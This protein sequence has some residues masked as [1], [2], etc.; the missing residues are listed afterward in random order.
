MK[1]RLSEK[2]CY[3]CGDIYGGGA[4]MVFSLLFMNFLVLVEGLPVVSAT[5]IIF[6]GKVWDAITDPIVG[7]ISD[8]TRTRFGRRRI[9]FLIGIVPVFL[10]F[11][12]LFYS[13]G[14]ESVTAKVIYYAFSYMFFGTAF[15]IVMIP[16]NAILSDI[17]SDYD[18]RTSFTTMRMVFSG[19]A[20]LIA[21]VVPG[22]IIKSVGGNQNGPEQKMG[23]LIMAI[24][25]GV[26]FG[27]SWL[28]TF[29]GTRE[30][31]NLPPAEKITVKSY[32]SVFKNPAYRNFLGIFLSFQVA[33]DLVLALFIFYIDIVVLKYKSYE[34]IVG[35]LLVCSVILMVVMGAL[36]RKKGKVFPLFIGIPVWLL[37]TVAFIWIDAG[38]PVYVL[39][40][41]AALIAVGSAA[42]NLATWSLLT[43]IYDID[44][45]RTGKRREGVYSGLTTF[46]RKFASGVAV[47]LLGYGLRAMGFD[48]NEYSVLK[49][50]TA[51]FDPA[52]YAQS[53]VVM[54]IKWMFIIIPFILLSACLIFAL[55]NK[56]NKR[57]FDA[58]LKGV[59]AFKEDGS[60]DSLD[61][62]ELED[63]LV[64]AGTEKG[65]L[66]GGI[67]Q[68][69]G[70]VT[71]E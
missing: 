57:R 53:G 2:L 37:S 38:T 18:E 66:W 47:L 16:Y 39:F 20:S 41:L 70:S 10:S 54:G 17:T 7:S 43:D 9:F 26:I 62:E 46:L 13:F 69:Q 33:V 8:R 64:A 55:R 51:N 22:I 12:T 36:A 32:A 40:I 4:F 42:G 14:L 19:G 27:V 23:Y 48:Q 65:K 11:I 31:E 61:S 35:T 24:A 45:I 25:L 15:T 44:E 1:G 29:L 67:C 21:A 60:I 50:S 56:I 68:K 59:A 71:Y 63:V 30:Q 6:I 3:A 58:V 34:M 5:L 52:V 49:A 28:V